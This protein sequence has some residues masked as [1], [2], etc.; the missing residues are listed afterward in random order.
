M[1]CHHIMIQKALPCRDTVLSPYHDIGSIASNGYNL[2]PLQEVLHIRDT[3]FS[4]YHDTG[5]VASWL[6]SCQRI[7]MWEL[8]LLI[9]LSSCNE[10][11]SIAVEGNDA[12]VHKQSGN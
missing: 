2:S 11:R 10:T 4:L 7:V 6:H 9:V 3:I 5:S 8:H 12:N 1:I